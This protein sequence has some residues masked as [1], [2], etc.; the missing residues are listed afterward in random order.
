MISRGLF[1]T[2]LTLQRNTPAADGTGG[3]TNSWADIGSFKGRISSVG[4]GMRE[5]VRQDKETMI[6]T[7]RIY[8]DP[9]DVMSDNRIRWGT[10]YFEI[11]GITNPSE[12]F[13]HLELDVRE[14]NRP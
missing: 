14:I 6:V 2:T 3:V 4:S 9:M 5:S 12:A 8:C 10:Y 11:I 1:N 13:S 7:H